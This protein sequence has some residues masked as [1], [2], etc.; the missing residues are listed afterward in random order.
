MDFALK[1]GAPIVS[2]LD[3]QGI[4]VEN[5]LEVLNAMGKM[6]KKSSLLSGVVPQISMVLGT[7]AGGA[8]FLP[9]LGDFTIMSSKT[10]N[11]ES[12]GSCFSKFS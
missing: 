8:A 1:M 12:S 3:S 2:I 7:C 11:V 5:G 9:V 4:K 10:T 6:L